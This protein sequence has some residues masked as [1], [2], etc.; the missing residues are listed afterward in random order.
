VN[1]RHQLTYHKARVL[2]QRE[3]L[4]D[5]VRLIIDPP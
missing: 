1:P 4:V 3:R 2:A 5:I